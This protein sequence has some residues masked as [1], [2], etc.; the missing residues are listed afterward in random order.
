MAALAANS[1]SMYERTFL[2][3]LGAGLLVRPVAVNG[4]SGPLGPLP[5]NR[6]CAGDNQTVAPMKIG[7][8]VFNDLALLVIVAIPECEN[9]RINASFTFTS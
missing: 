6:P 1:S 5:E 4:G 7:L 3:A 2:K 9:R 8:L